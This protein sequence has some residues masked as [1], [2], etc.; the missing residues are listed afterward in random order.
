MAASVLKQPLARLLHCAQSGSVDTREIQ[1]S[2]VLQQPYLFN[3]PATTTKAAVPLEQNGQG[4][5]IDTEEEE[6]EL[7]AMSEA[8]AQTRRA[9]H[10]LP[11]LYNGNFEFKIIEDTA[12]DTEDTDDGED[13]DIEDHGKV[14]DIEVDDEA[15]D[16]EDDD[17]AEDTKDDVEVQETEDGGEAEGTE[18]GHIS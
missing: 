11:E 3:I 12:E 1:E 5:G 15:E 9:H 16:T 4:R 2:R 7:R 17:K 18:S 8:V 13:E 14:E 10:T 6:E